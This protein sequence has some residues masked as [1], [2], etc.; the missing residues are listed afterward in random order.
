MQ[1]KKAASSS[2]L[3][4]PSEVGTRQDPC[5]RCVSR[6]PT[7]EVRCNVLAW[8]HIHWSGQDPK[9]QWLFYGYRVATFWSMKN[10]TKW[11]CCKVVNEYD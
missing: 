6:P 9:L 1:V 11:V 10:Q 8:L 7:P 5:Q 3:L 2:Y 4:L